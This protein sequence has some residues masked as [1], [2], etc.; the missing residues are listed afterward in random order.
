MSDSDANEKLLIGLVGTTAKQLV[1]SILEP[2]ENAGDL[3]PVLFQRMVK[4]GWEVV[5][6]PTVEHVAA[7]MGID[8]APLRA[9]NKYRDIFLTVL[10]VEFK[11][12]SDAALRW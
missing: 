6:I 12:T 1:S 5:G 11:R 9:G 8:V 7:T 2:S 3:V 10:I 4:Q